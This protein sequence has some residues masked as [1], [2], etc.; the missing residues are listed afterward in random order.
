MAKRMSE[1]TVKYIVWRAL[2]NANDCISDYKANRD[3]PF[4]QGKMLAYYELL[5]T[6]SNELS[7]H[8]QKLSDYGLPPDVLTL[9][10][11]Q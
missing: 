3:D 2:D 11:A 8:G 6:I 7:L 4:I 10:Y 5:D 9:L 1:D